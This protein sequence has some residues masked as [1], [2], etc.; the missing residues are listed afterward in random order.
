MA[1]IRISLGNLKQLL[2]ENLIIEAEGEPKNKNPKEK[3]EDSIDVQ[4]DRFLSDYE[5]QASRSKTEGKDWRRTVRRILEANDDDEK[6]DKTKKLTADDLD[7]G[8]FTNSVMRLVENY[9]SLLETRNTILR[10]TANFLGKNYDENVVQSFK[11]N[12]RDGHGV[13][14]GKASEDVDNENFAAP[15]A[16]RSG[17][18]ASGT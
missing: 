3:G 10:R 11:D 8:D 9:D 6:D 4:I 14:I 7:L 13:E 5:K 16:E 2:R 1:K 18:T 12:L 17:G 15:F